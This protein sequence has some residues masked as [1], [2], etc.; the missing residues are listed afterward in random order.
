M[1]RSFFALTFLHQG[2][3]LRCQKVNLTTSGPC[4]VEDLGSGSLFWMDMVAVLGH[5]FFVVELVIV[6]STPS[7]DLNWFYVL[8]RLVKRE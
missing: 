6:G 3:L 7:Q 2:I 8:H 4:F 1:N 5:A